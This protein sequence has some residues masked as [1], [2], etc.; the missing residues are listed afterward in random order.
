MDFLKLISMKEDIIGREI[1]QRLLGECYESKK[2]ELVALYGRRRVGKTYLV[3]SMYLDKFDFFI[4]GKYDGKLED[5]LALWNRKLVEYSKYPYLVP[6]NWNEAF[7]QLKHYIS[8][9]GKKRVVIFIDEMPWLDTPK[10]KFVSEFEN[11][12]ND[13]ASSQKNLFMIICGS[14]TTWMNDNV[15][16][17]KGGLH[18]R[19]TRKI[20]LSQFNLHETE[21]F[22]RMKNI[23]WSRHQI[24]ECYMI[25]GGTPYYLDLL[26]G[27]MSLP[28]NVDFLFFRNGAE[29]FGEYKLLLKSLFK[30][31]VIY[32]RIIELF[33]KCVKGM[34]RKEICEKL[35]ISDGGGLTDVLENLENCDFIRSYSAFG[36]KERD[37]MYQ[38]TDMFILFYLKFVKDS[39]GRDEEFWSHSID[40]PS[41]RAWTGYAFEQLCLNH[42]P[43]IKESLGIRGILSNV[44]SWTQKADSVRRVKGSQI[45]LLIER[46]D[47]VINVCEAKF[48]MNPYVVTKKYLDEMLQRMENFRQTT[49][50]GYALHLT[51]IAS[52]GVASNEY[53]G[54][55]QSI[56]TLR[57]LFK[58]L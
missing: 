8:S 2:A 44:C 27:G 41:K 24:A 52:S 36:K 50:T 5:E 32:R 9:L 13:W 12:W 4:T 15:I 47:Q 57:D 53:S 6:R 46:R 48:S 25:L 20:K 11:F 37:T 45:D 1:E 18:N 43:Q 7:L 54:T 16:S 39:G 30:N 51:L 58:E 49:K 10:S 38:L 17:S 14:A 22:L 55:V 26:Q 56:V 34:T 42:I 19:V 21:L 31:T 29:L 28:Q 35:K 23:N 33:A 40:N 3:K